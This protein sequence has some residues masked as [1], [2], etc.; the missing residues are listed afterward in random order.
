V[1]RRPRPGDERDRAKYCSTSSPRPPST[2]GTPTS[3]AKRSSAG[4]H[5]R[6]WP[7]PAGTPRSPTP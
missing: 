6:P 1:T 4:R 3:S 5:P 2:P 7:G